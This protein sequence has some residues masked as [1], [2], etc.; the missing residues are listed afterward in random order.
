VAYP[1]FAA[2]AAANTPGV[3]YEITSRPVNGQNQLM[4]IAVHGGAI[5]A[6]TTQLAQ[7]CAGATG[8]FYSLMGVRSS[9]NAALRIESTAFD[10]PTALA[11]VS[12]SFFT[13]SW[14]GAS[15]SSPITHVGGAD[16]Y[17]GAIVR[18]E[19]E[20]AGFPCDSAASETAASDPANI[21]NR[22]VRKAGVSL[23]LSLAQR[24]AFF[25]GADLTDASI[26]D[27]ANRT[28]TFYAYAS[29]V[30]RAMVTAMA[31]P[32]PVAAEPPGSTG[33]LASRTAGPVQMAVPFALAAD[34]SLAVVQDEQMAVSDRVRALVG[35]LPGER[36]MRDSYG[37][38]TTEALFA[39]DAATAGA[40]VQLMVLDA[41]T[42][43]EPSAVVTSISPTIDMD[44]GLVDVTVG[45]GR[46][47]VPEAEQPRYK[48]ISVAIGGATTE[49]P[50]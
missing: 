43:F 8:G 24:Q 35:T 11:L 20:A 27:P 47:D 46:A 2:L 15:G 7:F 22:N 18:Q 16:T 33:R 1:N 25:L 9:D 23:A 31:P 6:P 38:P 44:L 29:A 36:V 26:N 40:E 41:V 39:P 19:L 30:M 50:S 3:D 12:A 37:V 49:N 28:Q 34:G 42:A 5:E 14:H 45:V 21:C 13:V 17:S 4:H 10:E 48:T 32:L